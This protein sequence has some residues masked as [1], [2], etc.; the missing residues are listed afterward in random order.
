MRALVAVKQAKPETI[1]KDYDYVLDQA[2][3]IS[4]MSGHYDLVLKLNLS[5]TKFFPACSS[6]PWQLDAT[7]RHL[8]NA[9]YSPSQLIPVENKTV[10]TDPRQGAEN[11][12][13]S[14]VFEALD[15]KFRAL[16]EERWVR[17]HPKSKLLALNRIFPEGIEIPEL[18][19]GKPVIHFPTMKTHGHST[20]TGAIKNSFGGLLKE[21]RHYCHKHMHEVLVDLMLLQKEIH[22]RVFAVMD[23]TTAGNGAGPRTMEPRDVGLV[24]ASQDSV[25]LDALAARIM[26]FD[27]LSIPYLRMCHEMELGIADPMKIDVVGDA[28]SDLN[29]NFKARRSLVIWGDQLLRKGPLRFLEKPLLHSKAVGWAPLASNIYHDNLWYPLVG[30]RH[31]RR[32]FA[33]RWGQLFMSYGKSQT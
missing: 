15:L 27:P 3:L 8:I 2:G 25:A 30:K 9:G 32:F 16:P 33:G 21:V 4:S 20:T 10:V 29:L 1:R 19:V 22:P 17:W 6:P 18:F 11:N 31:V 28:V 5:W 24:L 14:S 23:G 13:W 12:H 7:A 26:G